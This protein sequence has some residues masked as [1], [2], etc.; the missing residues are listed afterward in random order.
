MYK[1]LYFE[2][3]F[4]ICPLVERG[5]VCYSYSCV[6]TN[7]ID[8]TFQAVGLIVILLLDVVRRRLKKEI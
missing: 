8:E 4:E 3:K 6:K 2:I 1:E 7:L 5:K